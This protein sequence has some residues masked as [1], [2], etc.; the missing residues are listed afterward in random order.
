M[1]TKAIWDESSKTYKL[2]GTKTWISNSPVADVFVV[3][4]RSDRHNGKIK[5]SSFTNF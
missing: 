4:A 5:V 3:W 2:S 1:E